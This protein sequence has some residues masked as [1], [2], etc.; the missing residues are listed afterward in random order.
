MALRGLREVNAERSGSGGTRNR[1]IAAN[2]GKHLGNY[3]SLVIR[4][5]LR[6]F[7]FETEQQLREGGGGTTRDDLQSIHTDTYTI[8]IRGNS[9]SG[10]VKHDHSWLLWGASQRPTAS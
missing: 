2:P 1:R 10:Q 5:L 9:K 8:Q 3:L 7:Y 6:R 4:N